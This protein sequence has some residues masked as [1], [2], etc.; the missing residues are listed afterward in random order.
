MSQ[1][2]KFTF[3]CLPFSVS[4]CVCARAYVCVSFV[5]PRSVFCTQ[6]KHNERWMRLT[7]KCHKPMVICAMLL[8]YILR[9]LLLTIGKRTSR[10]TSGT[11]E[12]CL[13]V[14]HKM[15]FRSLDK[16]EMNL[17]II[18]LKMKSNI[19]YE[20]FYCLTAVLSH[21]F[22]T[23]RIY[24]LYILL[25][26]H[27]FLG[28]DVHLN[29]YSY[30]YKRFS[31]TQLSAYF[32]TNRKWDGFYLTSLLDWIYMFEC[33]SVCECACAWLSA[34]MIFCILLNN[35][36][37]MQ[38]LLDDFEML[39]L[40]LLAGCELQTVD[41]CCGGMCARVSVCLCLKYNQTLL[42]GQL[43]LHGNCT[44]I[45]YSTY[46]HYF[47]HCSVQTR[48]NFSI[49]EFICRDNTSQPLPMNENFQFYCKTSFPLL[50]C[51]YFPLFLP[52]PYP[53]F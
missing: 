13:I 49:Y 14:D 10:P 30:A 20:C 37:Y 43:I 4:V 40:G 38:A 26:M 29:L 6:A 53:P 9:S 39:I 50:L 25:S 46:L 17:C 18:N 32:C 42:N 34:V 36:N 48:I 28:M 31:A 51:F 2:H 35:V 21:T 7:W 24:I 19:L 5:R 45:R 47:D 52:R 3:S 44:F 15:Y 8:M 23:H 22:R 33:R 16:T 1:A 11:G 12:L 27:L 41:V